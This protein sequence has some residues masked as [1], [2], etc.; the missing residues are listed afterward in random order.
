MGIIHA[1]YTRKHGVGQYDIVK[2]KKPSI[3][4]AVHLTV[5]IEN[6]LDRVSTI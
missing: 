6:S 5:Q 4:P 2:E 1:A 3:V